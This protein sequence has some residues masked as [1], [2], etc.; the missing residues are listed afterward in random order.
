MMG[1]SAGFHTDQASR[2]LAKEVDDLLATQLTGD[3]DL[4]R[5]IHD[6]HFEYI[7]GEI[8]AD[9]ITCTWTTLPAIRCSTITLWHFDAGS[10]RRPPHHSHNSNASLTFSNRAMTRLDST[11]LGFFDR[12]IFHNL[13]VVVDGY[14]M[15]RLSAK[16][17]NTR[18]FHFTP[19]DWSQHQ[20]GNV[21][22]IP[23]RSQIAH[24]KLLAPQH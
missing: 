12:K 6:V 18:R 2:N 9:G 4:V 11:T 5:A 15:P 7:L 24:I 3:D 10:G 17:W 1:G 19:I 13:V 14:Q 21:H 8:N 22:R 23:K 20:R 16:K